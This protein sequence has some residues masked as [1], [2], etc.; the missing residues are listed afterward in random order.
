MTITGGIKFF[1]QNIVDSQTDAT[2]TASTGV[3]SAN[4]ILD[5]NKYT[6]WRSSGSSDITIET[7]EI[8]LTVF[9]FFDRL[10]LVNHNFKSYTVKYWSGSAWVDFVN[11]TGLNGISLSNISESNYSVSSS[12][13]EFDQVLTSKI[14]I[15]IQTTQIPN[16]EKYL[17]TFVIAPELGTL[18]GFPIVKT[19][20]K[21][22][23]IRKAKL[24]NGR[25]FVNK[26]IETMK[27][28]IDFKNYPPGLDNDLNLTRVLFERDDSFF[29]WLCGGREGTPYFKYQLP[30]FRIEDLI[31]MQVTNVFND[32]YRNNFYNGVINLKL[33]LE[34][35]A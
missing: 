29:V 23:N 18:I 22:K 26:S 15:T 30:G 3:S 2:V 14:L 25:V 5:R 8:E 24:L 20:T 33:R 4:F 7:L 9:D 32:K 10:F 11:V 31:Q 35:A 6:V 1:D 17:N 16:A 34:E 21:N 27:F 19:V 12:Y 13:Y 28:S